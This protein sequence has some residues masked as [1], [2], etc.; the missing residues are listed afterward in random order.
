MAWTLVQPTFAWS[1]VHSENAA[2]FD[3][4][5]RALTLPCW[6]FE[7]GG[8]DE[9]EESILVADATED[10]SFS[11]D[12]SLFEALVLWRSFWL[13]SISIS[14]SQLLVWWMISVTTILWWAF[15]HA[16]SPRG[17]L[18][19][20]FRIR[21]EYQVRLIMLFHPQGVRFWYDFLLWFFSEEVLIST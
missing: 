12:I 20:T 4:A 9:Q 7:E 17:S 18:L 21:P 14:I 5:T 8:S 16:N 6:P 3:F 15:P 2:F 1:K 19:R 13:V 11:A 10:V